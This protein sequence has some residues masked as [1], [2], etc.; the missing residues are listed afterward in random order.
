MG[1][2][3]GEVGREVQEN[4]IAVSRIF[5]ESCSFLLVGSEVQE[6]EEEGQKK[7]EKIYDGKNAKNK[8]LQ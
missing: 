7:R 5:V 6:E 3:R 4:G 1:G 8:N 2:G